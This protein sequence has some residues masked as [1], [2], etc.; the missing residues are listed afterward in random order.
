[1]IYSLES[2]FKGAFIGALIGENLAINQGK[3]NLD[4]LDKYEPSYALKMLILGTKTIKK[5]SQLD[6]KS[7]IINLNKNKC[8]L[9]QKKDSNYIGEMLMAIFPVTLFYYKNEQTFLENLHLI[10]QLFCDSDLFLE[11]VLIWGYLVKIILENQFSISQ[12]IDQLN[13][14]TI[15]DL[16]KSLILEILVKIDDYIKKKSSL[17]EV[18]D[19]LKHNCYPNLAF[20]FQ[21]LYC[22][23]SVQCDFY[24]SIKRSLYSKEQTQLIT[25]LTGILL[26][27]YNGYNQVPFNWRRKV[28]QSLL[29]QEM[30]ELSEMLFANWSGGYFSERINTEVRFV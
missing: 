19:Y 25:T 4:K 6:V 26:G 28:K 1:M 7:W 5:N 10:K 9:I 23:T 8:N 16:K 20:V 12:L 13:T 21:A 18:S 11:N 3:I 2:K 22:F 14:V 29:G 15:I 27:L 17:I 30:L 24:L